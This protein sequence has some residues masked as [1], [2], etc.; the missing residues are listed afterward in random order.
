VEVTTIHPI[1]TNK[2]AERISEYIKTHRL[3]YVDRSHS[4]IDSGYKIASDPQTISKV[5]AALNELNRDN[6][7][8]FGIFGEKR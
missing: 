8:L 7:Q 1:E 6:D 3:F 5:T 2:D 4:T